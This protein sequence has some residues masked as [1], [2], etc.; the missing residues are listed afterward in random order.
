MHNPVNEEII[1]A[2]KRPGIAVR[3]HIISGG[4]IIP[5]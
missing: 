5:A 2:A 4:K 3:D 1:D